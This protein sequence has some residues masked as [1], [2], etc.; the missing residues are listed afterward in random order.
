MKKKR[1]AILSVLF[2]ALVCVGVL[3]YNHDHR[4]VPKRHSDNQIIAYQDSSKVELYYHNSTD[5]SAVEIRVEVFYGDGPYEV[6]RAQVQPGETIT[7]LDTVDGKPYNHFRPGVFNGRILVFDLETGRLQDR[8]EPLEFRIYQS[9]KDDYDALLPPEEQEREIILDE[10][11]Y[12]PERIKIHIDLKTEELWSGFYGLSS[13]WRDL[14][15]YVYAKIN[16]EERLLAKAEQILP[17]SVIFQVYLEPGIAD[18]LYM[19][20]AVTDVRVDTYYA[21]TGEFYDSIPAEIDEIVCSD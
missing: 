4:F 10:K 16:G 15:T 20:F 13:E 19:G 3:L 7:L 9:Y 11:D 1:T 8:V 18:L 6:S 12:R 2:L 17:R 14:N 21:D 5:S